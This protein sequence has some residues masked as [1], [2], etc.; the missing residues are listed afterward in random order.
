MAIVKQA[1]YYPLTENT[2]KMLAK[3]LGF[4]S[5]N[6]EL[7]S[8]EIGDGNL[9]YVFRIIS[10]SHEKSIIIKQALPYAK[11]VGESM[12][13]TLKRAQI[14]SS[15]LKKYSEFTPES[16]PKV[17]YTDSELAVTIMED[18]SDYKILRKGLNEGSTYPL[19]AN[20]VGAY[21]AKTLFF[22][23][24]FGLNGREKKE[25]VGQFIN[26]ELCKITEDLVFTDP[27]YDRDSNDFEDQL[28]EKA[29]GLWQDHI[30]KL[31]VGKL[32]RKFLTQADAL[33]HG[34]LH[35]GSIFVTQSDTKI[36]D[37]EFAFFG[38]IGFDIGQFFANI[39]LNALSRT[40]A[41]QASRLAIISDT[42]SVF[43]AEFTKLWLEHNQEA[44]STIAGYLDH[45]LAEIFEDSIGFAGCEIIRRTIGLA[46]V[47]DLD[48]IEDTAQRIK[49]KHEALDLGRRLVLQRKII[50]T[51]EQLALY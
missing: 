2:A 21:L 47:A 33:L 25:L 46:H 43:R 16:V 9:N 11:V 5:E 35:T 50:K 6:E 42:W 36:I 22:T 30:L 19:L 12:P 48:G 34:D 26:P 13:L 10:R 28:R 44:Y 32:K 8:T 3:S 24:D 31:E 17:F 38:P 49:A 45:I 20:H 40:K 14:E 27:F 39:L 41:E 1:G 29:E 51:P 18:L 23:S 37:P 4:F 7:V 15:A